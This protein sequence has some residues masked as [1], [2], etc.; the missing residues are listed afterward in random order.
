MRC[1]VLVADR[2][3]SCSAYRCSTVAKFLQ[4]PLGRSLHSL[5]H[6]ASFDHLYI[7]TRF[8]YLYITG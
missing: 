3:A 4:L 8:Y 5:H 6:V 1:Y 2:T 7:L